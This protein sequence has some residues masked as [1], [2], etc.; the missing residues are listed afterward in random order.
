M[1]PRPSAR[2]RA[3]RVQLLVLDVDGVLTDG[4]L[5]YSAAGEELKRF[6]VRDGLGLV[7]AQRAGL[8][9]AVISG[10]KSAAAA[11]RLAELGVAEVHLGVEDKGA[12][13]AALLDRLGVPAAAAAAMGDDL[14]DLPLFALVGLA[15]APRDAVAEV[16]RKAHWVARRRGGQ[17]AVR[18]A[19]EWLLR[20]RGAWPRAG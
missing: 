14:N 12:A 15:L 2:A 4:G 11:R 10:R 8:G 3:A 19:V 1:S 16:R 18:E 17:G 9:V 7:V 20:A 13:L 5:W 6:D